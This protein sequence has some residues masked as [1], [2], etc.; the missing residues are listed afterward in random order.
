[1]QIVHGSTVATNALLQRAG[2]PVAFITAQGFRDMLL[3]GRQNRPKLYAL[4]VERPQ[5]IVPEENCFT[6]DECLAADGSVVRELRIEEVDRVLNEIL[7]RGIQHIAI[8]L[9]FSFVNASHEHLIRDRAEAI[10]MTATASSDLLPEF[11]EYE[12][13]STTAIN[14]CRLHPRWSNTCSTWTLL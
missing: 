3:I 11:R 10:G 13:A 8:C 6:V 5:P 9:L 2:E 12:R 1:M 7:A 4:R 14:A